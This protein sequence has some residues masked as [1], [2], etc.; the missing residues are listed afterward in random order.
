MVWGRENAVEPGRLLNWRNG[1]KGIVRQR[2]LDF[3]KGRLPRSESCR[4]MTAIKKKRQIVSIGE[5]GNKSSYAA[6]GNTKPYN[7][8]GEELD[9]SSHNSQKVET[10][11]MFINW[12]VDKTK[13]YTAIKKEQSSD[14]QYNIDES[15]KHYA[16]WRKA[17]TKGH[18]FYDSIYI[19]S[20]E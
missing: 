15:V 11:H 1:D 16:K 3:R 17:G 18:V 4:K 8:F 9:R 19:K 7:H 12:W 20:P 6:G 10:I 5:H 13:Y 2:H 14:T